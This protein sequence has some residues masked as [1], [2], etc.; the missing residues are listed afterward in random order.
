MEIS[1]DSLI[2][3][4]NTFINSFFNWLGT[5]TNMLIENK[6]FIMIIFV[7]IAGVLISFIL[8]LIDNIMNKKEV[9]RE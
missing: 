1:W 3:D 6:I 2:A 4:I 5:I 8:S 7:V 9:E